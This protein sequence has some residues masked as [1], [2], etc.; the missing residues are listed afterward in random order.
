MIKFSLLALGFLSTCHGFNE[1]SFVQRYCEETD[2]DITC[3]QFRLTSVDMK[4]FASNTF[5]ISN[6][7][8]VYLNG[9]VGSVN[10]YLFEKFP[11]AN[12]F[13]VSSKTI[14]LDKPFKRRSNEKITS[15]ISELTL[16]GSETETRGY[17]K[18]SS[19]NSLTSLKALEMNFF[20]PEVDEVLL[21]KNTKLEILII[22][23]SQLEEIAPKAFKNLKK[24][25]KL[26][27]SGNRLV[28]RN[29]DSKLFS[30]Q[31]KLYC[32]DLSRNYITFA[33]LGSFWPSSLVNLNLSSNQI[34]TITKNH[35]KNLENLASLDLGYNRINV[36][37]RDAFAET[38]ELVFASIRSNKVKK[39]PEILFPH[40]NK[41]VHF[42]VSANQLQDLSKFVGTP[43]IQ[44][45]NASHNQLDTLNEYSYNSK[46]VILDFSFNQIK[47][48][49]FPTGDSLKI[50]YLNSN[51]IPSNEITRQKFAGVKNLEELYLKHNDILWVYDDAFDDLEKLE[52]ID[53]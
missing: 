49:E 9:E 36:L 38:T 37:S 21:A 15:K 26:D 11:K 1:T 27:L 43:G 25:T 52:I 23:D 51:N 17:Q 2:S 3:S 10:E 29:L 16:K 32:L 30:S 53:Y 20:L 45:L 46:L 4:D 31:S 47:S 19:L 13:F 34:S 42:D 12:R 8:N 14:D 22:N 24:L 41:L 7:E 48:I 18:S 33:P 28:T 6:A 40:Q 5:T 35:F 50:V 39:A 44:Y